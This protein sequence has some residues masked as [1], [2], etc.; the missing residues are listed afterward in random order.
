MRIFL[1]LGA[2]S[3]LAAGCLLVTPLDGLEG[4]PLEGT[5][6]A[7]G[8]V[9]TGGSAGVAGAAGSGGGAAEDAASPSPILFQDR[10]MGG[11]PRGIA[12]S[13]Q[14]VYWTET[15]PAVGIMYAPKDG[16]A[17]P[18]HVDV[19]TDNLSEPFD[20]A[21]DDTNLYWTEYR[22]GTV[23]FKPLSG[24]T[25][26]NTYFN[27]AG[28]AAYLTMSANGHIYLTDANSTIAA[29]VEG[30]PSLSVANS[31]KPPATG[32]AF[33]GAAYWA[34]GQPSTIATPN[35]NSN[36][37]TELYRPPVDVTITGLA[38]DGTNFYWIENGRSIRWIDMVKLVPQPPLFTDTDVDAFEAGDNIGDIAVDLD[39]IYFTEPRNRFIY[40]LAKPTGRGL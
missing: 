13:Q 39:W 7:G 17:P 5:G 34:W 4:P 37:P 18:A 38:C 36:V 14:G 11:T 20:V 33:C 26:G 12:L 23:Q 22:Q 32:I 28:H 1:G 6:G 29:I 2:A 27:G 15:V 24:V 35:M 9:G 21:V 3:L 19:K 31:Q 30:P 10:R 8:N 25:S 40:K 16:L